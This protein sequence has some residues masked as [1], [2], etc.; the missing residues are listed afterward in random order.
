[1]T[2]DDRQAD[3]AYAGR[4]AAT[5]TF[6]EN[7]ERLRERYLP[8]VLVLLEDVVREA[9][10][11]GSGLAE[12]CRYQFDTG[13][14]RLRALLP[15]LVADCLDEDPARALAMGAAC[16]MVHNATLVHDDVQDGDE[17]RRGRETVWRRF[18]VPRAIDLGDA[19]FYLAVLL[20]QR[21]PVSAESREALARRLLLETLKVIDGQ[22]QEFAL[23]ADP[24]P[25]MD[26][27]FAMVEAKTARLFVL[28]M[29]GA[30]ELLSQGGRVIEGLTE[31]ARQLGILF[32]VQDDV[33][34]L[35]GDK[36][37]SERGSDIAEG[38]RSVLAVHALENAA[39]DDAR[40]LREALDK[41]RKATSSADVDRAA[42][43]F[44]RLGSLAFAVRE[45]RARQQAA[46]DAVAALGRP[47]LSTMVEGMSETVLEPIRGLV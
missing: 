21:A 28:A 25:T 29:A 45:M 14:K 44:D 22:E 23:H 40:W 43:L 35:Y 20:A 3:A 34:D 33:L 4:A 26:R 5:R 32:Q 47:R 17:A 41:D 10:L 12:M 19:M 1:M 38:K 8:E 27:Y 36:G 46:V 7:F 18:G 9:G 24:R 39:P 30:A 13:G 16:E 42:E 31:A 37:R 6:T 2:R 11:T 15:L